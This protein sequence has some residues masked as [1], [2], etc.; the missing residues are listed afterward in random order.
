MSQGFSY[1]LVD[2]EVLKVQPDPYCFSAPGPG[3]MTVETL[4]TAI[5]PG[6][7]LAAWSGAPP[8]RPTAKIYPRLMGYC[9]VSRVTGVDPTIDGFVVG[10]LVLT[11]LAHRSHAMITPTQVLC[12]IPKNADLTLVST[13][14]LFHLGYAAC[15]KAGITAGHQV[16]VIGLGTLGMTAAAMAHLSGARVTGFSNYVSASIDIGLWGM[17]ETTGKTDPD[18]SKVAHFDSVIS[19]T[20]DW[21][22]WQLALQVAR[23]GGTIVTIGFPG[24]GQAA[25]NFNPLASQYFYDKQLT[26]MACGYTPDLDVAR[27]DAQFTLKRNCEFLMQAIVDGRLPAADLIEDIRPAT[28]LAQIYANMIANR[29]SGRTIVLD[30]QKGTS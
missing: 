14:Y 6:T 17:A 19:T 24:R 7:E 28:D 30:W 4:I 15:L 21:S 11:H 26:M 10:D 3:Q 5:S 29:S 16:A 25:P 12:K 1:Q 27:I 23:R 13:T 8:L 9:N 18:P 20:N 22:D 2:Q